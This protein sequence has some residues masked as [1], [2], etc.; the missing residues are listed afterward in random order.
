MDKRNH[1]VDILTEVLDKCKEENIG[2]L[3]SKESVGSINL[4]EYEYVYKN[5][6]NDII[7]YIK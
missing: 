6:E 5:R 4:N 2:I 7:I 3:I 1:I